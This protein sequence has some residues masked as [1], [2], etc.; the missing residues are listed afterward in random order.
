MMISKI[1]AF[2]STV[3]NADNPEDEL[4]AESDDLS[5]VEQKIKTIMSKVFKIDIN[6]INEDTAAENI[7]QWTSLEHI[8]FLVNLQQEFD[9]EFADAQIV[10]MFSYRSAVDNVLTAITCKTNA[11]G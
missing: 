7:D 6:E 5:S 2:F 9:I 3:S 10:E 11:R 1:K 4:A 8:D